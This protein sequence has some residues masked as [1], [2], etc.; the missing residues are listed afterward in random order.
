MFHQMHCLQRIRLALIN[1]P[2][3]HS[4]HCLNI[5]RQAILCNADITLDPLIYDPEGKIEAIDGL[6]VTHVCRDWTQVY[7]YIEENQNG[8]MWYREAEMDAKSS[9]M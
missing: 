9:M 4:G 2:N 5:L 7:A 8:P 3:S 6:G 1:G